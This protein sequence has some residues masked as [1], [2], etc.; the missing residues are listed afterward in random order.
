MTAI[1][2]REFKSYFTS[3]VGY[4]VLA[5]LFFFGGYFFWGSNLSSNL[6]DLTAVYSN[7]MSIVL[8]AVIPVLTMRLFSEEKRQKTDQA[9]LTAPVSLTGIV[10]GKFLAALLL[11]ALGIAVTFLYAIIVAFYQTPDWVLIMGNYL[12]LLLLGG[13]MIAIGMLIS[14]LTESM[15]VAALLTFSASFLL[16]SLDSLITVFTDAEWVI[17][18]VGFLSVT[19]RYSNF[20][21]GLINY[22]DVIFFLCM[23]A[24]FVFLTVRVLDRKRWS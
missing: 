6:A 7:L 24:L 10:A 4:I 15:F 5:I 13:A 17:S 19:A 1:F 9:L 12:G 23:E 18:A 11:Y 8:M 14:S 22:N 3:S 2:K 21:M 20:A 16:M